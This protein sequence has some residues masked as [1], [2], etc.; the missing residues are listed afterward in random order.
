MGFHVN[1]KWHNV[2]ESLMDAC[3][4][5]CAVQYQEAERMSD[6]FLLVLTDVKLNFTAFCGFCRSPSQENTVH[7]NNLYRS[8]MMFSGVPRGVHVDMLKGA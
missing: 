6:T 4:N 8:N 3:I 1:T 2:A 7:K 5:N